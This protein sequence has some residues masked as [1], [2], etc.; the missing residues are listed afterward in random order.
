L[1]LNDVSWD[2]ILKRYIPRF[3]YAK[4]TLDYH[5]TVMELTAQLNDGHVWTLSNKLNLYFGIYSLPLKLR[6]IDNCVT[7]SEFFS[8]SIITY[9]NIKLGDVIKEINGRNICEMIEERKKYYSFSNVDHYYRRIL[10]DI[11]STKTNDSID[12]TIERLGTEYKISVKPYFLYELYSIQE[13]EDIKKS[14]YYSIGDSIG[15][16]NLKYLEINEVANVFKNLLDKKAIIIDIRNYPHN[17]LYELS[18]FINPHPIDFAGVFIPDIN[19]PG[20]YIRVKNIQTG[21]NNKSYYKGELMLLVDERTQSHAEF[22]AMC[23]Q[24]APNVTTIGSITAGADG[25]VSYIYFPGE[26]ITY[27]TNIGILYPDGTQTQQIGIKIDSYIR[28][29]VED[30]QNDIDRLIITAIELS[31]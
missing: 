30:L 2:T 21:I 14:S 31:K 17:V 27:F 1:E 9:Y 12:L 20:Q 22:T 15:Y 8:D 23:L 18:K 10:E 3:L 29:T 4:D 19:F 13:R 7:V 16:V 11:L 26:I 28:P 24:S 25:N 6:L 5:L